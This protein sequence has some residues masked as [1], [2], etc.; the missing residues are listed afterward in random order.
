M[1]IVIVVLVLLLAATPISDI[2]KM[3]AIAGT[4]TMIMEREFGRSV[5]SHD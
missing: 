1:M 2:I 5:Q 3:I 4:A